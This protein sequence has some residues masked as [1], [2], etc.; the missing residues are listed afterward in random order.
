[1]HFPECPARSGSYT[2]SGVF[3]ILPYVVFWERIYLG[4]GKPIRNKTRNLKSATRYSLNM[5]V[6]APR[7]LEMRKFGGRKLRVFNCCVQPYGDTAKFKLSC[8]QQAFLTTLRQQ[9]TDNK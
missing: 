3:Y 5:R 8:L 6:S 4:R 1:M 2:V 7:M 9:I